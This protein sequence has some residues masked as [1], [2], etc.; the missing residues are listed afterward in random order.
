MAEERLAAR[1]RREGEEAMKPRIT[2]LRRTELVEQ[3]ADLPRNRRERMRQD[4]SG[5]FF[6]WKE[7]E[8]ASGQ[9]ETDPESR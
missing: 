4:R 8:K 2:I 1:I 9:R 6:V 5:H 3:V 7:E